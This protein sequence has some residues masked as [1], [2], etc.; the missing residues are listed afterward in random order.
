M[1]P[2][3]WLE[4]RH[5]GP[6]LA[7]D[8][9]GPRSHRVREEG[10]DFFTRAGAEQAQ[11]GIE[12]LIGE[13]QCAAVHVEFCA[14]LDAADRRFHEDFF[15]TWFAVLIFDKSDLLG[16]FYNELE[17]HECL[18]KIWFPASYRSDQPFKAPAVIP[19][20]NFSERSRYRMRMGSIAA[21]RLVA[22]MA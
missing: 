18:L 5:I 15:S 21:T 13:G 16:C 2:V 8:A 12:Q 17:R 3:A 20:I 1:H 19:W 22:A 11:D 9:G 7:H 14:V 10:R 4:A 6:Y